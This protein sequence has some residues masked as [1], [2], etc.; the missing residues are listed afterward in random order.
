MANETFRPKKPGDPGADEFGVPH[1]QEQQTHATGEGVP[2]LQITGKIPPAFQAMMAAQGIAPPNTKKSDMSGMSGM[3]QPPRSQQ[4]RSQPQPAAT[5]E[6]MSENE[7]AF[8]KAVARS[9]QFSIQHEQIILPSLGRFYNDQD[10]PS[11]GIVNI[12]QMTGEEEQILATPRFTRKGIAVNMIFQRCLQE[13]YHPENLLTIDRTFILIYL[14]GISY[15]PKYEVEVKCPDTEKKFTTDIDLA[16]LYVEQCPEDFG[17]DLSDVLPKSGM[18]F[19]YRLSRGSDEMEIQEYR[20]RRVK[21]FGDSAADDTITFRTALLLNEIEGVQ[22]KKELQVL[23]KNLPLQDV[24]HIRNCVNEPPFGVDTKVQIISPFTNE[25]FEI[26]LP[27][28][29]GFFFPRK[30][31]KETNTA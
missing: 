2:G 24:S 9:K 6:A 19:N 20:D 5:R 1:T 29:A 21:M 18:R 31:K 4:P 23:L 13:S 12:R 16:S 17:P 25:E 26:E 27:L 30:K 3:K 10:G 14:R 28:E 7:G 11:T 15:S 22:D 8:A